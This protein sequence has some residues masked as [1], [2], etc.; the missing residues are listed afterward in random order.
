ML[1]EALR[2]AGRTC[3]NPQP[4]F[5]C[6]E[7]AQLAE[8]GLCSYERDGSEMGQPEP[9]AVD[10]PPIEPVSGDDEHEPSND[11]HDDSEVH[12]ENGI[13]K[14]LVRHCGGSLDA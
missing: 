9:P 13:G 11:E 5:Q 14:N 7:R 12:D 4:G 6:R 2:V 1:N 8:P 10:P 3:L